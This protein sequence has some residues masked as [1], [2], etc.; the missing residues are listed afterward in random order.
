MCAWCVDAEH[1]AFFTNKADVVP[2]EEAERLKTLADRRVKIARDALA[3]EIFEGIEREINNLE[4]QANTPRKN[5]KV[6]ELKA[7]M[8][9]VIHEVIPQILADLKKKY[10]EEQDHDT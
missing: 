5:V 2:R 10:K 9:W 6:E 3:A 4:Y 8:D 7:Q 1:C